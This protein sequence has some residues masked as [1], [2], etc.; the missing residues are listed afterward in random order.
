MSAFPSCIHMGVAENTVGEGVV[1]CL[2]GVTAT[3]FVT[4]NKR[5]I[6]QLPQR[7]YEETLREECT[8]KHI[9]QILF[10][11]NLIYIDFLPCKID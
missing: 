10:R 9:F 3:N 1:L 11:T 6:P 2:H 7:D 4:P 5:Y 8:E